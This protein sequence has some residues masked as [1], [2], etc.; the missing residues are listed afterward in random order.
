MADGKDAKFN[1]FRELMKAR[2]EGGSPPEDKKGP[3]DKGWTL[4][5]EY[6]EQVEASE[7]AL[8]EMP[9]VDSGARARIGQRPRADGPMKSGAA[10][11]GDEDSDELELLRSFRVRTV[12]PPDVKQACEALSKDPSE[13]DKQ[14]RLDLRGEQIYTIDGADA[15]DYDDAIS[16]E[17]LEDGQVKIG[18]HIADVGHYVQEGSVLDDEALARGTSVYLPDQ[19]VPMLPEALSN[20]LCSLVG[21]R[22]RLAFSVFMVF[23]AKG[24][25][26]GYSVAKSVICS[27]RRCTYTEVQDLFDGEPVEDSLEALRASLEGFAVWTRTQQKLRDAKGSLR[28]DSKEKKFLFDQEGE[29][30]RIVDVKKIFSNTLIEETALAANQAVGDFFF[31]RGLPTI[32]RVHPEKDPDEIEAV[33]KMLLEHGIRVPGKERLTGRDVGRLIRQAR[34]RPNADALIG[35]IMGLVERAVYEVKDHEDVAEHFGLARKAYLHF[36]SPIRRYPDLIVHRW[37]HAVQSGP[38]EAS[39]DLKT[40]EMVADLKVTAGH[41][42]AQSEMAEMAEIAVK[43]LKVCQF[44]EPH[45]DEKLAAKVV[46]VSRGGLEVEL[47]D[48]N[49]AGFMPARSLG[50]RIQLKGSTM[51]VLIGRRSLSFTEGYAI[52]VRIKDVDFIRL[53]IILE[54]A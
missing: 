19:V 31:E 17:A 6:G 2:G 40:D 52:S 29:V 5:D 47:S 45:I 13:E 53:Q 44:M 46:R 20:G 26:L 7:E 8:D 18:V 10:C 42:S 32:Y 23:D 34:R 21:G 49:V 41:S 54:L 37:L 22:D 33:A 4:E 38:G 16:Y 11:Y 1:S 25:R 50:G 36:T 39:D 12:F 28:I 15:R 24:E 30:E 27:V 43:D 14:G 35:R 51:T 9:D 3:K 48:F